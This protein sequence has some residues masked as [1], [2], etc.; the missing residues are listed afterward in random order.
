[1]PSTAPAAA[2]QRAVVQL[3]PEYEAAVKAAQLNWLWRTILLNLAPFILRVFIEILIA[4][5]GKPVGSVLGGFRGA[6]SMALQT[7]P[8]AFVDLVC[9]LCAVSRTQ[10][11]S[12]VCAAVPAPLSPLE[13]I[14]RDGRHA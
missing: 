2:I 11:S 4:K 14:Y 3:Q 7:K 8:L 6:L 13:G 1:M 12:H 9:E 5:Y 10:L